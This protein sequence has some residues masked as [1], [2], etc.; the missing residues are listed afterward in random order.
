[1]DDTIVLRK[2][3]DTSFLQ[4]GAILGFDKGSF[5]FHLDPFKLRIV[6]ILADASPVF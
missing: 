3:P 5:L 1:M 2:V 6:N 4:S